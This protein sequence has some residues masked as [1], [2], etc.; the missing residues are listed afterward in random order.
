[1]VYSFYI[2]SESKHGEIHIYENDESSP[3]CDNGQRVSIQNSMPIGIFLADEILTKDFE[4]K[5]ARDF[6]ALLENMGNPVCGT[7]I[8]KLYH[9]QPNQRLT[10]TRL[11][12]RY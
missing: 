10:R 12:G 5:T 6:A 2:N 4:K 3:L 1:M 8:S 9:T 7:C 11:I